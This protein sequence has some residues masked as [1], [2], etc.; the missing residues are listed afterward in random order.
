MA[1]GCRRALC[2]LLPGLLLLTACATTTHSGEAPRALLDQQTV[3]V[4]TAVN[5][6]EA[7]RLRLSLLRG[8]PLPASA[9]FFSIDGLTQANPTLG[10]LAAQLGDCEISRPIPPPIPPMD[11]Q[12]STGYLVLQRGGDPDRPCHGSVSAADQ[13]SWTDKAGELLLG[14]LMVGVVGFL[15]AAPFI[16]HVF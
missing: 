3:A 7:E 9:Q 11:R 15:V 16:F 6:E 1:T 5:A 13:E 10:K 12:T 14:L 8:Q 4:M 2:L